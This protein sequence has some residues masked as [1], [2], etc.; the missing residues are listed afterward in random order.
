MTRRLLAIVVALAAA[1]GVAV[2]AMS[3]F[4]IEYDPAKIL[5]TDRSADLVERLKR[6]QTS[7]LD[8][9]QLSQVVESLVQVLDEEIRERRLL[10]EQLEAT[11]AELDDLQQNLRTR[12]E[13]SFRAAAEEVESTDVSEY[14]QARIA[15]AQSIKSKLQAA[16]F[17]PD[18]VEHLRRRQAEAE[19]QQVEM[20]DRARREGW[21]GTARYAEEYAS[22]ASGAEAIRGELGD[23]AYDR[24]MYASGRPNRVAVGSVIQ[25]SPAERA[26]LRPGD[27]ITRYGGEKIYSPDQL[28]SLRS[29]G[30]RGAPV[31]VEILRNGQ[32]MLI[33]MP[34]GPMG[35]QTQPTIHDPASGGS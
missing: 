14:E 33:S 17:T 11:R 25:T 12:V 32:V 19:M 16:G 9:Q 1:A 18:Q 35:I 2:L 10:A 13:E 27:I 26:G 6:S 29:T 3:R 22:L 24:Y 8:Q 28:T 30:D 23:E 20:D 5:P 31:A 7:E 15:R 4:T 34:R 21:F